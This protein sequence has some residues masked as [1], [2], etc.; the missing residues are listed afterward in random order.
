MYKELNGHCKVPHSYKNNPK[1]SRWVIK[2]RSSY[3][4]GCMKPDHTQLLNSHGFVWDFKETQ[5][6]NRLKL[7]EFKALY[8]HCN[9]PQSYEENSELSNCLTISVPKKLTEQI[10]IVWEHNKSSWRKRFEGQKEFMALYWHCN[11]PCC[12][13]EN[14]WL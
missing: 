13:K 4:K 9:V 1:L 5:W 14:P 2:H 10:R 6:R 3:K 7:K 12:Y 11:M 8:G